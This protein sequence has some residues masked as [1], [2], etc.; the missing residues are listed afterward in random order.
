[1][2]YILVLASVLFLQ[3]Q[4]VQAAAC[5]QSEIDPQT[6]QI[7]ADQAT[8]DAVVKDWKAFKPDT[9][10]ITQQLKAYNIYKAEKDV[11]LS[12]GSDKRAHCHLGCR[13]AQGASVKTG[14][15]AGWKKEDDDISD[16]K[17]DTHF[18]ELDYAATELGVKAS[19]TLENSQAACAKY[20]TDNLNDWSDY[21]DL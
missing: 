4:N 21:I 10:S 9:P 5:W 14:I 17:I 1:M 6:N 8:Y 12:L 18:D 11:A 13:I 7:F 2:K 16:C 20:C 19:T 15:Y 3:T